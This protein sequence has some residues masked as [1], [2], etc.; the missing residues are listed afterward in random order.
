MASSLLL[1]QR[2]GVAVFQHPRGSSARIW[3]AQAAIEKAYEDGILASPPEWHG[4][5]DVTVRL[6]G[7]IRQISIADMVL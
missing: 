5:R 6:A 3:A 7:T 2:I 4:P 1:R